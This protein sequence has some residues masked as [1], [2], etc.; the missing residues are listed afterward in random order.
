MGN[1]AEST[2]S[3]HGRRPGLPPKRQA[4]GVRTPMGGTEREWERERADV[5]VPKLLWGGT[6]PDLVSFLLIVYRN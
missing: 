3:V 4:V 2:S 6:E 5:G 1:R